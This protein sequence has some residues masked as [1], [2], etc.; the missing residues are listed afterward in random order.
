M[1]LEKSSDINPS[2]YK[3]NNPLQKRKTKPRILKVKF[4]Y[5]TQSKKVSNL[6]ML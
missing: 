4:Q 1:L 5:K 6:I 3:L 2:R